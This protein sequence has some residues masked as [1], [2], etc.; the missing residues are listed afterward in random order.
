MRRLVAER[1]KRRDR[2]IEAE[3]AAERFGGEQELEQEAGESGHADRQAG[4]AGQ[5]AT[6]Q[7]EGGGK[8]RR[9]SRDA[10]ANVMAQ[11]LP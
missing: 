6:V 3:P 1:Q 5:A 8:G 7:T 4:S 9:R 2:A 10:E 11:R